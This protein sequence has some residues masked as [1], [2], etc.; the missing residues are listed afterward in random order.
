MHSYH[1]YSI[2]QKFLLH[3]LTQAQPYV[4]HTP[5]KPGFLSIDDLVT[6][7]GELT[8]HLEFDHQTQTTAIK[9]CATLIPDTKPTDIVVAYFMLCDSATPS[10]DSDFLSNTCLEDTQQKLRPKPTVNTIV[11]RRTPLARCI[12]TTHKR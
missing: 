11:L 12:T 1:S 10:F 5:T 9:A 8:I 4:C 3:K 2:A 7:Q 6:D